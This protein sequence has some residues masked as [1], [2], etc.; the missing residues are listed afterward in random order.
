ML[1]P[2]V[3]LA[4]V[5][6]A[7]TLGPRL[8]IRAA[9]VR[10]APGWGVLA[11][12]GL[13]VSLVAAIALVTA[14]LALPLARPAELVARAAGASPAEVVEHYQTPAGPWLAYAAALAATALAARLLWLAAATLTRASRER[15]G[16]LDLLGLVGRE[17]PGGFVVVDHPQPMVY[18]LP[19]R[20][21]RI[22]VTSAATELL[23]EHELGLV[24][25]HERAHLRA[26][27]DLAIALADILR[28]ALG[29]IRVFRV[30]HEQVAMLVEMQADDAA[31][32]RRGLA[33]AL[34][35]LGTHPGT[36]PGT[37]SG[38]AQPAPRLAAGDVAAVV[39][40][41][42]LAAPLTSGRPW[43]RRQSAVVTGAILAL[44]ATPAALAVTPLIEMVVTGCGTILG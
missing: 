7:A 4:F 8:L 22:V 42:R 28:R 26:R 11:W 40:V 41:E 3:L 23:S 16:Q 5:A 35:R 31:T 6:L 21:S 38:T 27:H 10:R 37:H 29:P 15:R 2:L 44:L 39:R 1:A 17:H 30:A 33:G 32:D 34:V 18:C 36:H 24:L 9:W 19:G 25:A 13:T 43:A 12:Q 20:G 14:T